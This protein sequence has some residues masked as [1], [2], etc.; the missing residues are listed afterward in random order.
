MQNIPKLLK[1]SQK[2]AGIARTKY[3]IPVIL[4]MTQNEWRQ[5][6]CSG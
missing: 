5:E 3:G 4:V 2:E 6:E 1:I